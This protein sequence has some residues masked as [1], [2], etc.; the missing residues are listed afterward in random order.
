MKVPDPGALKK[1][2]SKNKYVLLVLCAGL[3]LLLLPKRASEPAFS[4]SNAPEPSAVGLPMAASGIPLDTECTRIAAVLR[5]ING[6]GEAGVLLSSNGCVVVCT[7]ADSP[8]VRLDVTNAVA[9]YTGLGSNEI[10]IIK[11]KSGGSEK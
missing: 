7:G 11:M 8:A 6:V 9:A 4:V 1:A 5:E 3:G 2:L 10:C